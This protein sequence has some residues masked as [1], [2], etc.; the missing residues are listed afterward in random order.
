MVDRK[1]IVRDRIIGALLRDARRRAGRTRAE[2]ADALGVSKDTIEAYEEGRTPI[3]L[4]EL[5]VLGYVVGIPMHRFWEGE[6]ELESVDEAHPDFRTVLDLRHRIVGTLLR[7][8]RLEADVTREG[9]ARVLGCSPARVADYEHSEKPIPVSELELLAEHLDLPLERFVDGQGGMVGEW[10]RRQEID[11][12]FRE[13][14]EDMQEFVADPNNAGYV[15]VA[16]RLSE[17]PL[18]SLRAV[19]E[20]LLAIAH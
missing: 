7:Q 8:T 12:R 9:L 11:R 19:A 6:P 1:L 16:M 4:P 15:E 2:C 13:L 5:E 3:S 20:G 18:N 10:H 14:P 17:L